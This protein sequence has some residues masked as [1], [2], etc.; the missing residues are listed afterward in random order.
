MCSVHLCLQPCKLWCIAYYPAQYR[1]SWGCSVLHLILCCVLSLC[2]LG[3]RHTVMRSVRALLWRRRTLTPQGGI[4]PHLPVTATDRTDWTVG[5]CIV[6]KWVDPHS[7]GGIEPHL[8]V[9][10]T[11]RTDWTVGACIVVKWV[12]PH[13]SGGIEPHLLVTATDRTDWTVG[14]CI[15]VKWVDPHS[16]G[17]IEPHLLVTA[18]DRTDEV[19]EM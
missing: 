8:L 13:S 17:G 7:S 19:I 15:V 12:D 3:L 4:E 2:V 16:S 10:A 6:V 11:D 1:S 5:T 9:T 14:T 18:T